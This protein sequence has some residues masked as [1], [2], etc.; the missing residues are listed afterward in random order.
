[1]TLVSNTYDGGTL[2]PTYSG[3]YEWDAAFGAW[4]TYPGSAKPGNPQSW[5]RYGYVNGDPINGNDPTGLCAV[6]FFAGYASFLTGPAA[7]QNCNAVQWVASNMNSYAATDGASNTPSEGNTS[8]ADEPFDDYT[9]PP[10]SGLSQAGTITTFDQAAFDQDQYSNYKN[11][12]ITNP[13]QQDWLDA[14]G[15]PPEYTYATVDDSGVI[16][17]ESYGLHFSIPDA[18]LGPTPTMLSL[19]NPLGGLSPNPT[20]PQSIKCSTGYHEVLEGGAF[21]PYMCVPNAPSGGA[22]D[23]VAIL[24]PI[25]TP[26]AA[27]APV[28]MPNYHF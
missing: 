5:N 17:I 27:P 9:S 22:T 20:Q 11:G 6:G 4:F 7:T 21:G 8:A 10:T 25:H 1:M 3:P 12:W 26:A 24:A 2:S 19:L 23:P 13:V 28:H 16:V 18:G 15:N 14:Y